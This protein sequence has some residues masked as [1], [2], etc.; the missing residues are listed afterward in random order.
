M[1]GEG[2]GDKIIVA[3]GEDGHWVYFS[4]RDDRLDNGSIIDF[5]Q[6]RQSGT[7]GDVRKALRPWLSGASSAGVTRPAAGDISPPG[8]TPFAAI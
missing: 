2:G 6:S 1:V 5:E 8:S 3:K 7:L 4:V